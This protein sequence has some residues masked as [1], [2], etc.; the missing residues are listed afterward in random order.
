MGFRGLGLGFRGIRG[1]RIQG[2]YDRVSA[3]AFMVIH[4]MAG[5]LFMLTNI[6]RRSARACPMSDDFS[7]RLPSHASTRDEVNV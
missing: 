7:A 5:C 1:I 2:L 3:E 6:E 4:L